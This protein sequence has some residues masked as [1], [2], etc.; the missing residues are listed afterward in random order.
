MPIAPIWKDRIVTL[1]ASGT[2]ADYEIHENTAAGTLLYSGRA[3]PRPGEATI[4][5]RINDI[6]ADYLGAPLPDFAN[7]FTPMRVSATFVVV[8][9]GSTKDTITFVNDWSYDPGKVWTAGS[10]LSDPVTGE[11]DPRQTIFFSVLS[12]VTTIYVTLNYT[13]GTSGQVAVPVAFT[14][15]FNDDFNGDFAQTDNPAT[16]GTAIL[17]LS[18]F[19]GLASVSYGGRTY[20]VRQDTCARWCL[21][22]VNAY[23]GWDTLLLDGITSRTDAL[24][25]HTA[26]MDYDNSDGS[27]RGRK[28]HAI[29]VTPTWTLRTGLLTDEQSA[30]MGHVLASTNVYLQDLADGTYYPVLIT[31][32]EAPVKSYKGNGHN[33]NLYSFTATLAQDRYRR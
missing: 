21:A 8:V 16:S 25:R 17:D 10:V 5:A 26:G 18:Q 9:G 6:C 22:Y 32:T 19:T 20:P 12:G 27:A 1:A 3:Y 24:Q 2:Y 4:R 14:A 23:G 31:D 29:E 11:L 33:V 15:D 30:K 28:D 13:D 7:R